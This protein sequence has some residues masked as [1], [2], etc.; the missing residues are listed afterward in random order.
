MTSSYCPSRK[1]CDVNKFYHLK[2]T[3]R[4]INTGH[5]Y[6][7]QG[8]IAL[9]TIS[10]ISSE[11]PGVNSP[12]TLFHEKTHQADRKNLQKRILKTALCIVMKTFNLFLC[13]KARAAASM[14]Q[15]KTLALVMILILLVFFLKEE[16]KT[17]LS[18]QEE[19]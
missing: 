7:K 2:L 1:D 19:N 11:D 14:S 13:V 5:E 4:C 8:V 3:T 10:T 16:M 6:C 15:T 17:L 9:N 18:A 12:D